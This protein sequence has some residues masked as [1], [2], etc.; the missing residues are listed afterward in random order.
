[1]P[2]SMRKNTKTGSGARAN[3]NFIQLFAFKRG[4]SGG[5]AE[6]KRLQRKEEPLDAGGR[7]ANRN[8][9]FTKSG[10]LAKEQLRS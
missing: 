1:M 7:F 4:R 6:K 10:A 2:S 3:S 5:R 9:I 8:L